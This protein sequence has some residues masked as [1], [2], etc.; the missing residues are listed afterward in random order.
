MTVKSD[1]EKA[2]AAAES[3]KGAYASFAQA[4]EDQGAKQMF[5]QMSI[6]MDRHVAQI[7]SRLSATTQNQQTQS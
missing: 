3:A 7:N 6:D 5:E 2:V 1:L 4:T